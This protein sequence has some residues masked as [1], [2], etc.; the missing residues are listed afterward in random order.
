MPRPPLHGGDPAEREW[1]VLT[2]VKFATILPCLMK[3]QGYVLAVR[4]QFSVLHTGCP[5]IRALNAL[6]ATTNEPTS[7][8]LILVPQIYF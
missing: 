8:C 1:T 7:I 2:A 3:L 5:G 6:R 4:F